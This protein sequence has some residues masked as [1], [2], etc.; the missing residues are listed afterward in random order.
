V[1]TAAP[2]DESQTPRVSVVMSVHN[3]VDR[4][5]RSVSSILNQSFTD[6]EF[7][8]IDDGSTDGSSEVLDRLAAR[9]SRIRV[10]CQGNTGLTR[11]LIRGCEEARGE[12][13]ARQDSDDWSHPARLG[14]SVA[15]MDSDPAVGLVSC[16]TEFVGPAGVRLMVISRSTDPDAATH[17]LRFERQGPPAHGSVLFRR[18][19]YESVGGYRWQ[20]HFAQDA[21]LWLRMVERASIAYLP[22]IRYEALRHPQS[23]SGALRPI[24]RQFGEIGQLCREA[25]DK[26]VAE[27]ELLERASKLAESVTE[28]RG[29]ASAR[30]DASY[31]LGAQLLANGDTRARGY[32]LEAIAARPWHLKA[33]ARLAQA[34]ILPKWQ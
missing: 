30:A 33:W 14:E 19:L 21:D 23:T 3:D 20:F 31:W 32:L 12:F 6:L 27:T 2:I 16:P 24:Q 17:A 9:D 5:E 25:R 22:Q 11:A 29:G 28:A 34:L 8:V 7:I 18:A 26:G 13:I 15:L 4:L 10:L 1:S